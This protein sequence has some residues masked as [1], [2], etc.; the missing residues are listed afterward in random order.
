VSNAA[1]DIELKQNVLVICVSADGKWI[2]VASEDKVAA[3]YCT[4]SWKVV[5]ECSAPKKVR[6]EMKRVPEPLIAI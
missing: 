3:V 4:A 5:K 6:I 1:K 2:F